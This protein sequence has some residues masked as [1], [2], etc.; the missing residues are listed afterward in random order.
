MADL[1]PIPNQQ[2]Q[3]S[4]DG[5][6]ERPSKVQLLRMAD[7]ERKIGQSSQEQVKSAL[8]YVFVLLGLNEKDIPDDYEKTVILNFIY[9]HYGLRYSCQDIRNAFELGIA[10][11]FDVDRELYSKRFS[12]LY[13]SKFMEAYG[14]YKV[15][16]IKHIKQTTPQ[17][18][19][20]TERDPKELE[21]SIYKVIEKYI[22]EH[23]KIPPIYDIISCYNV[24]V[25]RGDICPTPELDE[26]KK[27][28]ALSKHSIEIGRSYLS[29]EP[30]E[31]RRRKK[32]FENPDNLALEVK[33]HYLL[34]YWAK[35][36]TVAQ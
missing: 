16:M 3:N 31:V 18:P 21:E 19:E 13:L 33:R 20:K 25:R 15:S 36:L 30:D 27:Q 5:K 23:Q 4:S 11:A 29:I 26:Q 32:E 14:N 6:F 9:T 28:T 12:P 8:K 22:I 24:L 1:T 34:D 2:L 35:R 10:G 17:L 7:S